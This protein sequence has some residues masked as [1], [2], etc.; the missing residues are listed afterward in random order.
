M[1]QH[2]QA[3]AGTHPNRSHALPGQQ[4]S[5]RAARER[6]ARAAAAAAAES[7][8]CSSLVLL[9]VCCCVLRVP[10]R[11]PALVVSFCCSECDAEAFSALYIA[12]AKPK[13]T[14]LC[15]EC[16]LS[17]KWTVVPRIAFRFDRIWSVT[18][19]DEEIQKRQNQV[20]SA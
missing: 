6:R 20:H 15:C 3:G 16:A 10:L 19:M 11:L 13:K 12:D 7:G 14:A 5:T 2:Q 9:S 8:V 17:Y 1:E 4:L 18:Q